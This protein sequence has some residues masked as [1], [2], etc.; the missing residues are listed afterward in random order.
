L[1]T[2]LLLISMA[3]IAI[4]ALLVV[5]SAHA[6]YEEIGPIDSKLLPQQQTLVATDGYYYIAASANCTSWLEVLILPR[7]SFEYE[8][9]TVNSYPDVHVYV[10]GEFGIYFQSYI[11]IAS[12]NIQ[13]TY[14]Q[15]ASYSINFG[16]V[17]Y[18]YV[19][20]YI[21]GNSVWS[22]SIK[23]NYISSNYWGSNTTISLNETAGNVINST[24]C[25]L[26]I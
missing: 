8:W 16:G 24:Y 4:I 17:G 20:I 18:S 9:I 15:S 11:T 25:N 26:G 1:K 19:V 7:S 14:N 2:K 22:F 12:I 23:T 5:G 6:Y 21:N 10:A 13:N 3:S